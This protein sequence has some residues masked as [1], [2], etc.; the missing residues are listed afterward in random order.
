[1]ENALSDLI[2]ECYYNDAKGLRKI[3]DDH[4]D[5][6]HS[7]HYLILI[8]KWLLQNIYGRQ[9][10]YQYPLLSEDLV[11]DK[12]EFCQDYLK[13]MDIIDP[14]LSHNRG[15]SLWELYSAQAFLLSQEFQTQK[16]SKNEFKI[17]IQNLLPSLDEII[18]CLKYYPQG[19]LEYHVCQTASKALIRNKETLSFI[20]LM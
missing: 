11:R 7:Q 10:G 15:R 18:R 9:K 20:D 19:T 5:K 8:L 6:Y 12:I 13:A 3:L 14:G 1:M 4:K 17:G 2:E 16:I